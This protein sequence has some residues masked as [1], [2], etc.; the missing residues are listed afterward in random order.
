MVRLSS[1]IVFSPFELADVSLF[2]L[3]HACILLQTRRS[4]HTHRTLLSPD[5]VA[6][7]LVNNGIFTYRGVEHIDLGHRAHNEGVL[8]RIAGR[9]I[10]AA[11]KYALKFNVEY[12]EKQWNAM[13]YFGFS[14]TYEFDIRDVVSRY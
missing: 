6:E 13:D 2:T 12:G 7:H 10:S 14:E 11:M 9:G 5:L 4:E 8:R 3:L 1:S